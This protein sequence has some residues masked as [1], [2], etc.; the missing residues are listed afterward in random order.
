MYTKPISIIYVTWLQ[1]RN[2]V[3]LVKLVNFNWFACDVR[4]CDFDDV[5]YNLLTHQSDSLSSVNRVA[6]LTRLSGRPLLGVTCLTECDA[7]YV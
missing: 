4:F 3:P 1:F 6:V 5:I 7:Q 2:A